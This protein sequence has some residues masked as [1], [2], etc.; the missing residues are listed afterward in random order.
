MD[1]TKS[2]QKQLEA[3]STYTLI[4]REHLTSL[5]NRLKQEKVQE[6]NVLVHENY[7]PVSLLSHEIVSQVEA[8][9][10]QERTSRFAQIGEGI[11]NPDPT[12]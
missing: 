2:S 1:C 10:L 4:N 9:P 3:T 8:K 6:S 11:E 12:V 5:E 7:E